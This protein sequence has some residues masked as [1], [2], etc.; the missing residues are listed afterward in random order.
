MLPCVGAINL[1]GSKGKK[2]RS[3]INAFSFYNKNITE[4]KHS[5]LGLCYAL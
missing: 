4:E 3:S 2:Y 1:V 5:V